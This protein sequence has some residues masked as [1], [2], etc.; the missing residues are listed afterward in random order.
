MPTGQTASTTALWAFTTAHTFKGKEWTAL[1]ML[2]H[3]RLRDNR[4]RTCVYA[5]SA[6]C[7]VGQL[8]QKPGTS[9]KHAGKLQQE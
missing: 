2:K 4:Q 8:L 6:I 3:Q 9:T 7:H 5:I 1:Q